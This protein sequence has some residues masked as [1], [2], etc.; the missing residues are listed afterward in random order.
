MGLYA[1]TVVTGAALDSGRIVA[2]AAGADGVLDSEELG[3]AQAAAQRR[4]R[5]LLGD[6][7]RFTVVGVDLAACRVTVSVSAPRPRLLLGGGTF[8][9]PTLTRRAE[10]RLEVLQ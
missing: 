9:S 5:D 2:R 3:A 6:A 8:G 10:L 1:T 7:A 4:V